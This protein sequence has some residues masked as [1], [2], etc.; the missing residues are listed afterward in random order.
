MRKVSNRTGPN[1]GSGSNSQDSSSGNFDEKFAHIKNAN[2][3]VRLLDILRHYGFKIDKNYQRPS[4]SNNITCP[5]PSHKGAKERTPSFGYNFIGDHAHC[6]GCNFTGRAVEFIAAYEGV[7]RTSVAERILSQYGDDVSTDLKDYGEDY[8]DDLAPIF[9]DGSKFLQEQIQNHKHD[10]K[11]LQEIEKL[12][13]WLDFY[14]MK[15]PSNQIKADD[16]RYR[17]DRVKD[18]IN[19][20]V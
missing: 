13:W 19:G 2:K 20:N 7:T 14:M 4:W 12:I 16:L 3:K 9:L 11:K 15:M 18:L 8:E 10:S 1:T 5:L 17:F 6:F